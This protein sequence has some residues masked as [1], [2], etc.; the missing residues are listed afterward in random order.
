MGNIKIIYLTPYC[1][2]YN[3]EISEYIN[4]YF[5]YKSTIFVNLNEIL[6][7]KNYYLPSN[8]NIYPSLDGYNK[9]A[10]EIYK[11]IK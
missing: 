10:S 9:I 7:E 6:N 3:K 8:T 1:K 4:K 2:E 5:N 11:N